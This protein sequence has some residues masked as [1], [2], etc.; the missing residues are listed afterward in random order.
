M[1]LLDILRSKK[2][3]KE[4]EEIL[5]NI[6]SDEL[7]DLEEELKQQ[8]KLIAEQRRT[9]DKGFGVVSSYLKAGYDEACVIAEGAKKLTRVMDREQKKLERF[10]KRNK[11]KGYEPSA[12]TK[13]MIAEAMATLKEEG[14][15]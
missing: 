5:Q 4:Q 8:E 15:E 1:G 7:G 13:A 12:R 2:R 14:K 10:N 3:R 9:I 11:K 6:G